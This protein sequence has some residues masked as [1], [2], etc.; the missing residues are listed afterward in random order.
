LFLISQDNLY[1]DFLGWQQLDPS[2]QLRAQFD[3]CVSLLAAQGVFESFSFGNLLLLKSELLDSY[4]SG[5]INAARNEPDGLGFIP[6]ENVLEGNFDLEKEERIP[7]KAEE[8]LLL[9]ATVEKLLRHEIALRVH[10]DSGAYLVFPSQFT[11]EQPDLKTPA[12]K[13][14]KFTFEGPVL[15]IWA[16]LVVRLAQSGLF[17]LRD[18]W[19]N[20]VMFSTTVK[21]ATC[22]L[23]LREITES[24]AELILFYDALASDY[25]RYQFEEYIYLHLQRRTLPDAL[26]RIISLNCHA[27]GYEISE[28]V[29]DLRR[30]RGFSWVACPVCSTRLYFTAPGKGDT[31]LLQS[32]WILQ[33]DKTANRQRDKS[34]AAAT[35]N[36]K[37][38]TG[39]YDVFLCY[40]HK[41]KNVVLKIGEKLK[42]HGL[43]PWLDEWEL[44]PGVP[45]QTI[46]E[47]KIQSVKA[48][49]VFVGPS[50]IG[51]W[52][53]M[54]QMGFLREFNRRS[55]PV[56]PVVLPNCKSTPD[57]PLFLSAMTWVY[58]RKTT[59][60]P[61]RQLIWG[62]TGD[63]TGKEAG[64]SV[65]MD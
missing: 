46:L 59:P 43:L 51:P 15:N 64:R 29:I 26:K 31:K 11:R 40:N 61:L 35:L 49:A 17:Q 21:N 58:F 27:C 25:T 1:V 12:G 13:I 55:C 39:D 7:A 42:E 50:G 28:N 24:K 47:E 38:E 5:L 6:E 56:I 62:I 16:T 44:R 63:R 65:A 60:N 48:A 53:D 22:G 8:K 57:L 3:T 30:K 18:M 33:M 32:E 37:R 36:G 2:P 23:L 41:D 34:V 20:G 19:K 4:A 10:V 14:V 45:W 54:E 52:Q 9:I